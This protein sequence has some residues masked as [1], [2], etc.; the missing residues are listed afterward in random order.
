MNQTERWEDM[1]EAMRVAFDGLQERI[2]TSIPCTIVAVNFGENT[3]TMTPTI[4]GT[5][6]MM[7]GTKKRVSLP[8]LIHCPI[9]WPQGGGF[10][11]T[12][13]L[14]AGDEVLALFSCRCIDNWWALGAVKEPQ[15]E[16][17]IRTHSL[18]DGF[19]LAGMRSKIRLISGVSATSAQLRNEAGDTFVE[20]AAGQIVNIKAPGGI[21]LDAGTGNI[22]MKAA[23]LQVTLTQQM[24]VAAP[25]DVTFNTPLLTTSGSFTMSGSGGG[26]A[27]IVGPVT[28]S[29]EGTFNGHT[30]GHHTHTQPND[31]NGDTEAPT[32]TPT[33]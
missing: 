11:L 18:S 28:A 16:A 32:N 14:A 4:A 6:L 12:F 9:I 24:V 3:C 25:G 19:C 22:T 31:S 33:G 1:Q 7:D 20:V 15:P 21:N 13:P 26:T 10:V 8:T 27:N 30:V 5:Q 23:N 29:G 2:W 17:E